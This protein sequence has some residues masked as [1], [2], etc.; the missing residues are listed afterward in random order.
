[1]IEELGRDD[2]EDWD[3]AK[4]EREFLDNGET[5]NTGRGN[6]DTP[7]DDASINSDDL[8]LD[9]P[10][11]SEPESEPKNEPKA[12][13]KNNS[14]EKNSETDK[15]ES[16]EPEPIEVN[17]PQAS[18][19]QLQPQSPIQS[20]VNPKEIAAET[21]P[22]NAFS[23]SQPMP[24][25]PTNPTTEISP[26]K[27][28]LIQRLQL[29]LQSMTSHAHS[30]EDQL[31]KLTQKKCKD[32]DDLTLLNDQRE[33]ELLS[34]ISNLTGQIEDK[35][36]Q[37]DALRTENLSLKQFIKT[38]ASETEARNTAAQKEITSLKDTLETHKTKIKY[39]NED[40]TKL[41]VQLKLEFTQNR[42]ST[43]QISTLT[44]LVDQKTDQASIE[45]N[46]KIKADRETFHHRT[47]ALNLTE[48]N[49]SLIADL[50]N[51]KTD[52]DTAKANFTNIEKN[53]KDS[54][55]LAQRCQDL[56]DQIRS[57]SELMGKKFP[58]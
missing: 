52:L 29:Q 11:G 23:P 3:M 37:I 7:V 42:D 18:P 55:G 56:E 1:M 13:S 53:A 45:R 47:Q 58:W 30:L 57:N 10:L 48:K 41:G 26:E 16:H 14:N 51:L 49:K 27:D 33:A 31:S 22:V 21:T 20:L 17:I 8:D 5:E 38:Q 46:A 40:K 36:I 6:A 4:D 44:S 54:V 12:D 24:V 25:L 35:S 50:A 34:D 9:D 19:E 43:K 28:T 39:L 15:L 2:G 32:L